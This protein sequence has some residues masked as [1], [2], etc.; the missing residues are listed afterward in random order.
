MD[1]MGFKYMSQKLFV[2]FLVDMEALDWCALNVNSMTAYDVLFITKKLSL[3]VK[4]IHNGGHR[5]LNWG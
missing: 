4:Y 5:A 2:W 3:D 1:E